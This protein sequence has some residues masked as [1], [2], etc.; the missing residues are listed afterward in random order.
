LT[1]QRLEAF[2]DSVFAVAI[3]LLAFELRLPEV[4]VSLSDR[5]LYDTL[6]AL[7]PKLYSYAITFVLVGMYWIAHH[8]IFGLIQYVDR[9]LQWMNVFHL[10]WVCLLPVSA[11]TLGRYPALRTAA[12]GYGLNLL[13]IW[14]TLFA[15]WRY[16]IY[17]GLLEQEAGPDLIKMLTRR[18]FFGGVLY[19]LGIVFAFLD[20]YASSV[21]YTLTILIYMTPSKVD[22]HLSTNRISRK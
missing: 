8:H 17:K 16:A 22:R 3:T 12:V 7:W 21:I 11:T 9:P 4:A 10:L 6:I 1:T 15:M 2:S 14:L 5:E 20:P 18:I 19:A 13:L